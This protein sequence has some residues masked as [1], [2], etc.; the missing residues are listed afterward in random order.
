MGV[1]EIAILLGVMAFGYY[2][3]SNGVLNRFLPGS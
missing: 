1:K 2:L 3:G